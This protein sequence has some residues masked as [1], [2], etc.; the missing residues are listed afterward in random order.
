M[1]ERSVGEPPP[2]KK[3]GVGARR[4]CVVEVWAWG[5]SDRDAR[6]ERNEDATWSIRDPALMAVADG[7]GC[8][9]AGAVASPG[10]LV[11]R[12]ML[13]GVRCNFDAALREQSS[14]TATCRTTEEMPVVSDIWI[15]LPPPRRPGPSLC[16]PALRGAAAPRRCPSAGPRIACSDSCRRGSSAPARHR[17]VFMAKPRAA[18]AWAPP[19]GDAR[20]LWRAHV[21]QPAT[22][23][24]TCFRD[25]QLRQPHRGSLLD[26]RA[27]ARLLDHEPGGRKQVFAT[28]HQFD[29]LRARHRGRYQDLPVSAGDCFP[30][31]SEA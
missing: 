15:R 28:H 7:I 23:A 6:R 21:V 17:L 27:A 3:K 18:R 24:A 13:A 26:R 12:A 25:G 9:Q 14:S 1:I 8:H 4:S 10:G 5:H 29:R 31:C 11:P 30:L 19:D 2:P 22:R 16:R 20:P